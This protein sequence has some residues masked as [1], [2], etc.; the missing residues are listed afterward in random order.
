MGFEVVI[1]HDLM[2]YDIKGE[3]KKLAARDF[4]Q[5][6]CLVVCLL[7]HGIENAVA[8]FDGHY[9]NINKLKYKFSYNFCPSLYGKP[10]IFVVQSCQGE[11]EQNQKQVVPLVFPGSGTIFYIRRSR[12][13]DDIQVKFDVV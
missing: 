13:V 1:H 8:G 9:V 4:S 6:G 7:S 5:Y 10:K 12:L 11:L 3:M 2:S